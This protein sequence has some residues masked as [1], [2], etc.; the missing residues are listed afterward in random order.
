MGVF[1]DTYGTGHVGFSDGEIA[2][3][4]RDIFDLR[5]GMIEKNLKLRNPIYSETASYGHMG[6]KSE[7]VKK[8]FTRPNNGGLEEKEMEV[9][10]FT[11][12]KLDYKETVKKAFKI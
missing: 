12:E 3:K 10:L 1:V 7:I 8:K 2:Q 5:P 6:R 11:W 9:E 4:I